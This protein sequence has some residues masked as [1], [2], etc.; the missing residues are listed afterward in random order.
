MSTG[1][2]QTIGYLSAAGTV[3]IWT[4]FILIS[5]LGGKSALTGHDILALR[6]GVA[7][8]LL[9]PFAGSLPRG[10]WRDARL[11]TL[12]M[13]GGLLYG[14]LVY[15]GFKLVPAAH[16]GILLPGMQPF[17]VAGVAWLLTRQRM[18][19]ERAFGLAF[20]ALGVGFAAQ[21]YLGGSTWS[22]AMLAGDALILSSALMWAFYSVLA[23]RWGFHPW[24]LTRFVA[25]SSALVYLPVYLLWL[26]KQLDAVPMSTLLLQGL[27]QGLGATIVA[28]LLFLKAVEKLGA[29][30]VGALIALVPV[31]A[32]VAAAPLLDEA[33]T[34]WLLAG[35]VCVSLGAF[36]A[37]RPI[38]RLVPAAA[39]ATR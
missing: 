18:P 8:F 1:R 14:V 3:A 31:L 29:E 32:G 34:G 12:G 26:P 4:G 22:P 38:A 25:F 7:A 33:L 13:L 35:L 27:Y 19:R 9:L 30:R 36:I 37:A 28:M 2:D 39:P 10:S 23:K 24:L 20:I 16:G 15:A 6:L 21:S 17:L 5:R 11:W